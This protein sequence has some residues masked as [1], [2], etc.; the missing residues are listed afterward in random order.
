MT[1]LRPGT[2]PP[3]DA[4]TDR[5]A[6][7][8]LGRLEDRYIVQESL[9][10]GSRARQTHGDGSDADIAVVLKGSRG[11]RKGAARDMAGIAFDVMLE[12]GILI[13][14]LPLW[15]DELRRTETFANPALLDAI[16]RDAISLGTLP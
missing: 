10:F 2:P 12:T 14:A 1:T 3:I 16:R 5:A 4:D 9:L 6:R 15:E 13:E 8:F 7:L 11:D